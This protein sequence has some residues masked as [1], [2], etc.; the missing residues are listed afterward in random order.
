MKR[1]AFFPANE[2]AVILSV[3]FLFF[4]FNGNGFATSSIT[5]AFG[6]LKQTDYTPTFSSAKQIIE[7]RFNGPDPDAIG[8][9][10]QAASTVTIHVPY[11]QPVISLVASFT[12]SPLAKAYV[13][14][15]LQSSGLTANNFTNSVTYTVIAEDGSIR[16]YFVNIVREHAR[17][18]KVL[19]SFSFQGITPPVQGVIDQV[20]HTIKV[21]V[22]FSTNVTSLIA[23][24]AKSYLAT[25]KISGTIQVSGVT[26]N[27]YSSGL[28]YSVYAEDASIQTYLVTVSKDPISSAKQIT[29]FRF[30]GLSA[31]AIGTITEV[32]GTIVV[33]IPWRA[34]V[35]NLVASFSH[36]PGSAVRV[37]TE[38]QISGLTIHNFSSPIIYTVAAEDGTI[39]NYTISLNRAPVATG[40]TILTFNFESQFDPDIVGTIDQA[41]KTID[42]MVPF[43]QNVTGLMPSFISSRSST[44]LVGSTVQISGLTPN[45][46]TN[47]QVY[48]CRSEDGSMELYT[49]IVSHL[50]AST[51][52]QL[53]DFRFNLLDYNAVGVIDQT[54]KTVIIHV[55]FGT[56][57]SYLAGSYTISPLAKAKVDNL[58][59]VSGETPQNFSNPVAFHIIAEDNSD[60]FYTIT[61]IVD[62]NREKRLFTFE[63]NSFNPP[64]AG[65][66]NEE[67][68]TVQANVPYSAS[69]SNLIASFTQST[70]ATVWVGS[71]EQ[72]SGVTVNDFTN[73]K[74][75]I[76]EAEDNSYITYTITVS[77]NPKSSEAKITE[78]GFIGLSAPATGMIDENAGTIRVAIPFSASYTNLVASFSISDYSTVRIGSVLQTSGTTSNN[79]TAPLTYQV[80]AENGTSKKDYVVTVVKAP[81]SADKSIL[82]FNFEAQFEPDIIGT[83]DQAA[84]TI[85][86]VVPFAQDVSTLIPTFTSSPFSRLLVG[87]TYQ[88]SGV[89]NNNFTSPI[90]YL[91]EAENGST[92]LY[93]VTILRA[94][95]SN[96]KNILEFRF[97]GLSTEVIGVIDPNWNTVFVHV[98]GEASV[99]NLVATFTLSPFAIA[100]VGGAT[101]I[102]GM[103]PNNFT[104]P[105]QYTI[106]A[107][108]NSEKVFTVTIIVGPYVEKKILTFGFYGLPT[109]AEGVINESTKTIVVYIPFSINRADLVATFSSSERSTVWIGTVLQNSGLTVNDFNSVRTY[110]VRAEDNSTQD[111]QVMVLKSPPLTGN[112]I[113]TFSFG[114]L[115]PPVEGVIDQAARTISTEIPFGISP[116]E[117]VAT[118]SNSLFASV[119]VN[120]I[121]Q[122]SGFTQ[123][124]FSSPLIYRCT[125]ESGL[126]NEYVVNAYIITRSAEKDITYFAFEDLDP[127]CVGVI[128]QLDKSITVDVTVGVL[129]SSLRATFI[130]SP[131]SM[132]FIEGKGTQISGINYNDF[133]HPVVYHIVAEDGTAVDYTVTVNIITDTFAPIVTNR[134]QM[135]T[136]SEDQFAALQS[137]EA[138][139]KV[140]IIRSDA[141]QTSLTDLEQSVSEGLGRFGI[142][143]QSNTEIR[144][145]T[146]ALEPGIY[147]TYA[148]DIAGNKSERGI[149]AISIIDMIA[150]HVFVQGQIISNAL[151]KFVNIRSSDNSGFVYLIMESIPR[152]TKQQ[153]DAA[154]GALKG[155]KSAVV[156]ANYDV[157]VSTH[158]LLPGTY[159]A[160]AVDI[161]GNISDQST[162]SVVITQASHLN[163]IL[164]FSFNGLTPPAIGQI[165]GTD[166]FIRVHE[167]TSVSALVANYTLSSLA[168]AYVGLVQ[169]N[170]GI[171]P[172]DFTNPVVYTIE[173]EDGSIME[174][175]VTVSF[176]TGIDDEEWFDSITAFPN[177]VADRLTIQMIQPADL[178]QIINGLGQTVID[179]REPGKYIVVVE[180]GSWIKG[181][182]FI[183]YFREEKYMGARKIIKE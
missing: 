148:T 38:L 167:G 1:S 20:N 45:D 120:G 137:N 131:K 87:S 142:V 151:T 116:T 106:V 114:S 21:N 136:N 95:A 104:I 93:K 155:Q 60:G 10:N 80:T 64:V 143:T 144:I 102:S 53:L 97:I 160:F 100:K 72:V 30:I 41:S 125:S 90:D 40:N 42:L 168:N 134:S 36:S 152:S 43:T 132:V 3:L 108:D 96:L 18:G 165:V 4:N 115:T 24:F 121:A 73:P 133:T 16:N 177:P 23:T 37:G 92:E 171:L 12:L 50:A 91:C 149:N 57:I 105:V 94:P 129:A 74:A 130:N 175:T 68:K 61:V 173:A 164:A 107:E 65:V 6:V 75:Y 51:S 111:Y 67:V 8:Y 46:F 15:V 58:L 22:L 27:N 26:S 135:L 139:G 141:P 118:F 101:Q 25:V 119:T 84:K 161:Y 170:N 110:T 157:P 146:Y 31:D 169:Q 62:L 86:L 178:I 88:V 19:E 158:Q 5:P 63:F 85:K 138:T 29:D 28:V 55:P 103:T 159:R 122:F 112:R 180:T 166:I 128:N 176:N 52:R 153:L 123:N 174:Y 54:N 76:V 183:R 44:V 81:A 71:T 98:P 34:D 127:V 124:D 9:I 89:T 78:F 181:I 156:F 126:I 163:S 13:G 145:S 162:A 147:Y 48:N 35:S 154:V 33:T 32:A 79:F 109:L 39:K 99:T 7:F 82:S 11:S 77:N 59:Q 182:Y 83:I 117:L 56:D 69:R 2:L 14:G 17:T 66:I 150:P 49:V 140:Y 47:P 113:T 70:N 179:I 172:N